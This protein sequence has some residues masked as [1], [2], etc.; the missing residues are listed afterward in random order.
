MIDWTLQPG[1]AAMYLDIHPLPRC[2]IRSL[3]FFLLLLQPAEASASER[4]WSAAACPSGVLRTPVPDRLGVGP[5][6]P[7]LASAPL[8]A[9]GG[10]GWRNLLTSFESAFGSRRRMMQLATIG[11]CIGLYIMMR[12]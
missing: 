11:M 3:F 2:G 8:L 12:R 7:P 6:H 1:L 5:Q 10:W 9:E 4:S